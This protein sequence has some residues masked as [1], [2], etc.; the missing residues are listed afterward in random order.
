M[1]L[2]S[3]SGSFS[4]ESQLTIDAARLG[5]TVSG[6]EVNPRF[7]EFDKDNDRYDP[8]WLTQKAEIARAAVELGGITRVRVE[9]RSGVENPTDYWTQFTQNK[10]GYTAVWNHFYEKIND[11]GSP[12][13]ANAAGFQ[14]SSFDYYIENFVLPLKSE[15]AKKGL[16]LYVNLCF[17]DFNWTPLKGNLSVSRNADEYAEI[18]TLGA[19]RLR[20]KYGLTPDSV[21]IILEPDNGDGWTGANIGR[22]VLALKQRLNGAGLNPKIIAPSTSRAA[23]VLNF[24]N[25]LETVPGASAAIDTISYHRYDGASADSA[26]AGIRQRASAYGAQTAM[27]EYTQ[28]DISDFFTDMEFGG[29][30]A[31]QAYGVAEAVSSANAAK[32]AVLWRSPSGQLALTTQFARI[33]AIQREV[34]PGARAIFTAR[35]LGSDEVIAFRN[36]DNSE[37]VAVYSPHGSTA[38][39]A[40]LTHAAYR[41]TIVNS[42]SNT[43]TTATVNADGSGHARVTIPAGAVAVLRS[44]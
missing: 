39:I 14:W 34:L 43:S 28:G 17:V 13:T 42:G 10:I 29:G 6:W 4:S 26:V 8:A 23:A 12:S 32:A 44:V 18:M 25:D 2:A 37:V 1:L 31:W 22:A 15:L 3:C 38:D 19:E 16:G 27:L 24:L 41:L 20:D 9:L 33:A 40:G 7:W 35:Q 11:N 21:E 36:P 30:S 5:Q